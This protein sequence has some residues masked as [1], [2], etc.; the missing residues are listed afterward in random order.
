MRQWLGISRRLQEGVA[1]GLVG[2]LGRGLGALGKR[3]KQCPVSGDEERGHPP[4]LQ[5]QLSERDARE[6]EQESEGNILKEVSE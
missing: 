4:H 6:E 2:C 1:G 3:Q 5:A